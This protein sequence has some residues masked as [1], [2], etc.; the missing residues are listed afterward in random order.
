MRFRRRIPETSLEELVKRALAAMPL[1]KDLILSADEKMA[2]PAELLELMH[3]YEALTSN[4]AW[5]HLTGRLLAMMARYEQAIL[6]GERDRHGNDLTDKLRASY[7]T[8]LQILAIP[9]QIRALQQESQQALLGLI[10]PNLD[11]V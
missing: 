6:I 10:D 3:H 2:D 11:E 8:L 5:Q 7:G 1:P 4:P 9:A